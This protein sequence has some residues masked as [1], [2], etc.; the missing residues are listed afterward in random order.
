MT[1]LVATASITIDTSRERI[2]Q[3]LTDPQDI[4]QYMF[5]AEVDADW[6]EGSAITW[7]GEWKGKTYED[8]G[9]VLKVVAPALLAYSHYSP[10]SGLPDE[11]GNYHVVN[12]QISNDTPVRVTL[13]QDGNA[14]EQARRHSEDNWHQMLVTLKDYLENESRVGSSQ[15]SVRSR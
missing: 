2:W 13:T 8:K 11:P 5:G 9:V 12:I 14:D 3:A 15:P 1:E 6:T 10:L 7:R 4:R